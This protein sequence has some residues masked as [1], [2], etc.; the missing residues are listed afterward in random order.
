MDHNKIIGRQGEEQ[1]IRYLQKHGF[2]IIQRNFRTQYGEI[3]IIAEKNEIIYYI[4]VKKRLN[5][6]F[7]KPYEAINTKKLHRMIITAE[8]ATNMLGI[9]GEYKLLVIEI[10]KN[11]ITVTEVEL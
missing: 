2:S 4:E 11:T 10:L 1:A 8:V 3:D 7:G 6:H 9:I 5:T